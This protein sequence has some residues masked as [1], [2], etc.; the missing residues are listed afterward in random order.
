MAVSY[1]KLRLLQYYVWQVFGQKLRTIFNSV[2]VRK[3]RVD[4]IWFGIGNKVCIKSLCTF[5]T[6]LLALIEVH[7]LLIQTLP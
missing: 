7:G 1:F 2:E 5:S 6:A 3:A 4:F